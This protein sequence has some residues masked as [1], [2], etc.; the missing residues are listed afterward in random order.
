M[1]GGIGTGGD[2]A[3]HLVAHGVEIVVVGEIARADDLNAGIAEPP[4]GELLGEDARLRA[5]EIDERG[6]WIEIADAL[7]E[8]RKIRDWRAGY[9]W[10]R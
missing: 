10:I 5:R 8:R 2:D 9:G 6:V 1:R 4:F 7:Q 3:E